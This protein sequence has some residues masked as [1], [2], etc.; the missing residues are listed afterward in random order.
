MNWWEAL[1]IGGG[2]G[3]VFIPIFVGIAKLYRNLKI[4]KQIRKMLKRKQFLT[5]IDTRDYD[6]EAW[7]NEI[8]PEEYK[9]DLENLN[10]K[11][12]NKNIAKEV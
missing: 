7:K 2:V 3:L 5:P 1:L 4:K 6:S 10:S 8:N 9:K 12:F 11:I